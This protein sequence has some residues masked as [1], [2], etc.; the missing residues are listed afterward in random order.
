M[1][2]SEIIPVTIFLSSLGSHLIA[3]AAAIVTVRYMNQQF[4]VLVLLLPLYTALL[5]LFAVGMGWIFASLQVYLRDTAQMVLV[6]LT[7]WFWFTP[8]FI[9]ETSFPVNMR[10][11]VHWNPMAHIVKGYRQRLLTTDLPSWQEL[12]FLAAISV[13]VFVAGGI[14]FRHLKRGFADVL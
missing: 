10:F 2:P 7:G 5:G 4:S 8:I 14:F 12:L 3:V 6:V 9:D 11:L 13:A 1:F